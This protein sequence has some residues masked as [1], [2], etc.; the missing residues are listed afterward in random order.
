MICW[1]LRIVWICHKMGDIIRYRSIKRRIMSNYIVKFVTY[2]LSSYKINWALACRA[3]IERISRDILWTR[4]IVVIRV[5]TTF[6]AGC[7]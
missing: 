7:K 5:A 6:C 4:V 1:I 2:C 3:L